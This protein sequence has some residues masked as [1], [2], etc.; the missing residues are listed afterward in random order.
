MT[1]PEQMRYSPKVIS[2]YGRSV[3]PDLKK[4]PLPSHIEFDGEK[5]LEDGIA[6]GEEPAKIRGLKWRDEKMNSWNLVVV[7][8]LGMAVG[9][10]SCTGVAYLTLK[11]VDQRLEGLAELRIAKQI[12]LAPIPEPPKNRMKKIK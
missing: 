2:E 6:V 11:A 1:E 8:F 12:L 5:W 3:N 9:F 10:A 4:F 7:F